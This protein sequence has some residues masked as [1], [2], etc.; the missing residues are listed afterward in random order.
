MPSVALIHTFSL[1]CTAEEE[2]RT[3]MAY[4]CIGHLSIFLTYSPSDF[5]LRGAGS[6][7]AEVGYSQEKGA[8]VDEPPD[9]GAWLSRS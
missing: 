8:A 6:L 2:A 3:P 4:A 9:L 5:D 1:Q 7:E